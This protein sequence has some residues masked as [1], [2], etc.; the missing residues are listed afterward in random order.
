[1]IPFSCKNVSMNS[2]SS[3]FKQPAYNRELLGESLYLNLT[4][5][6]VTI[7]RSQRKIS[8]Q[9]KKSKENRYDRIENKGRDWTVFK[10]II[11]R[12][13]EESCMAIILNINKKKSCRWA[14]RVKLE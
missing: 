7:K 14:D 11:L 9:Q 10:N 12:T 1:M 4:R 3:L 13:V 8:K 2:R 6:K 5:H